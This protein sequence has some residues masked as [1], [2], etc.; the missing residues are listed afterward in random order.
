MEKDLENRI[1]AIEER[2]KKVQVDKAWEG[3]FVRIFSICIA[4]YIVALVLL[5]ILDANYPFFNAF[6][7]V[8][9]FILSTQSLP[10]IKKIW[11]NKNNL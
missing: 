7:P 1:Q 2:N 9:G 10:F 8:V 11:I 3:S 4:T 5:Y 6:V